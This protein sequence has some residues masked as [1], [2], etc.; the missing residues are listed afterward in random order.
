MSSQYTQLVEKINR[1]VRDRG[2]VELMMLL[3]RIAD[4]ETETEQAVCLAA[5]VKI[6]NQGKKPVTSTPALAPR[7]EA[8]V[9]GEAP[10][11]QVAPVQSQEVSPALVNE[12]EID[13]E[14]RSQ[15]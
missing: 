7:P 9:A 1:V 6:L 10:A 8:T 14:S 2:D 13:G 5:V 12:N 4:K 3:D 11:A 15:S